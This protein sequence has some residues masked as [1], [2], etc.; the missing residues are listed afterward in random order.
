MEGPGRGGLNETYLM[1]QMKKP[2]AMTV[3]KNKCEDAY[4]VAGLE[5]A[6]SGPTLR[7]VDSLKPE[8]QLLFSMPKI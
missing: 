6:R 1:A 3:S 2:H 7:G 5:N 4:C 8:T